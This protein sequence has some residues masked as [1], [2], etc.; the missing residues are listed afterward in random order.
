MSYVNNEHLYS[1][2]KQQDRQTE[3]QTIYSG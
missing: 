3:V 2:K 1:P